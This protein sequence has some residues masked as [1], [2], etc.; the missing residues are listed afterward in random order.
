MKSESN[1]QKSVILTQ[2]KQPVKHGLL[3]PSS[4]VSLGAKLG[5]ALGTLQAS[6]SRVLDGASVCRKPGL[7]RIAYIRIA[8]TAGRPDGNMFHVDTE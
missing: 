5:F 3:Q 8:R 7:R 2:V 4:F 1:R 6:V